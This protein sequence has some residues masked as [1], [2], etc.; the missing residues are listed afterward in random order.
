MV[1]RPPSGRSCRTR[2][3]R[4]RFVTAPRI[5]CTGIS[6]RRSASTSRRETLRSGR[7][8]CRP[9]LT[10]NWQATPSSPSARTSSSTPTVSARLATVAARKPPS[11][12]QTRRPLR[13]SSVGSSPRSGASA[14]SRVCR[15]RTV[16]SSTAP[17]PRTS[18]TRPSAPNTRR[19]RVANVAPSSCTTSGCSSARPRPSSRR[20]TRSLSRAWS[21]R[22]TRSSASLS[23]P[24]P[25]SAS[26]TPSRAA[27]RTLTE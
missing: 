18:V 27:T 24:P 5:S 1:Q 2:R 23:P 13:T 21:G 17:S 8:A 16:C 26:T 9:R 14:R 25:L 22:A 7:I 11:S 10:M 4:L 15:S 20:W 6:M 12:C 19:C 3:S